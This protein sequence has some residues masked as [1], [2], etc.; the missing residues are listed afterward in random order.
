MI[1]SSCLT[2]SQCRNSLRR[3][4]SLGAMSDFNFNDNL[5]LGKRGEQPIALSHDARL[6]HLYMIGQTGIPPIWGLEWFLSGILWFFNATCWTAWFG[7]RVGTGAKT[8]FQDRDSVRDWLTAYEGDK[9]EH[10]TVLFE[11]YSN[12]CKQHSCTPLV[13]YSFYARLI[14][15]G[16]EKFR[17]N[18]NGSTFYKLP[19]TPPSND[20]M[21]V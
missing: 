2:I 5:Y 9:S 17:K 12:W 18:G 3:R 16:A 4:G 1:G 10:C 7:T 13:R 14:E 8:N 20:M 21:G 6:R 19:Q 11:T 15:L